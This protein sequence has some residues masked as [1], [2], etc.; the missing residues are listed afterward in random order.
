M[1]TPHSLSRDAMLRQAL[2]RRKLFWTAIA[3]VLATR[4]TYEASA[5]TAQAPAFSYPMGFPGQPLGDGLLM[6]HG[7]ACENTWFVPG[8]WHTG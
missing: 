4:G 3:S 2:N 6:R 7:Y 5:Q 8:W 1:K